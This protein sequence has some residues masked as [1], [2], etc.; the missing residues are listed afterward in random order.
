MKIDFE[1]YLQTI[2]AGTAVD[3][4]HDDFRDWFNELT[5]E[6]LF[7]YGNQFAEEVLKEGVK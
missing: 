6:Q 7:E 3:V 4:K 5:A 1:S 2:H